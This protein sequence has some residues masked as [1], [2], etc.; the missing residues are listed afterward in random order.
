MKVSREKERKRR[1]GKKCRFFSLSFFSPQPLSLLL[2]SLSC[3]T[4][5]SLFAFQVRLLLFT[6]DTDDREHGKTNRVPFRGQNDGAE[7]KEEMK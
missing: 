6:I 5:L 3:L 1:K 4:F 7:T 2:F